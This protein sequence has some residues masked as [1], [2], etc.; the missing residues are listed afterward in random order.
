M[1]YIN[2]ITL[3]YYVQNTFLGENNIKK[4]NSF[5]FKINEINS[6]ILLNSILLYQESNLKI[7][8]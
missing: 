3:F 8:E 7:L 2:S 1:F 6:I 5:I 4:Q